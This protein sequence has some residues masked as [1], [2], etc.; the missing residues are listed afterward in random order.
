MLLKLIPALSEPTIHF[1]LS[2]ADLPDN[3]PTPPAWTAQLAQ[4]MHEDLETPTTLHSLDRSAGVTSLLEEVELD[5]AIGEVR[6][7]FIDGNI[8]RWGFWDGMA[9]NSLLNWDGSDQYGKR[10]TAA[11][12]RIIKDVNESTLEDE[13][14]V[15]EREWAKK[16][17][18]RTRSVSSVTA[19]SITKPGKASRHKKSRSFFMSIVSAVGCVFFV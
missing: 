10:L 17:A 4:L 5:L 12:E 15:R 19:V 11:L 1:S 6:C 7:R 18:E 9:S 2:F 16:R 14:V 3:L 8:E 13:R